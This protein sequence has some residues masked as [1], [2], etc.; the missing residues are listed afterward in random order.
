MVSEGE[1][2]ANAFR[3]GSGVCSVGSELVVGDQRGGQMVKLEKWVEDH[4]VSS[5]G[6]C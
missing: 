3:T 1:R 5:L 2:G 6:L 4:S